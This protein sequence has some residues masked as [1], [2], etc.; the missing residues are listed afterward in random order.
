MTSTTAAIW[1]CSLNFSQTIHRSNYNLHYRLHQWWIKRFRMPVFI[2]VF[3]RVKSGMHT[4]ISNPYM[5]LFDLRHCEVGNSRAHSRFHS[6]DVGWNLEWTRKFP[7]M[8]LF[9]CS[10]DLS[11]SGLVDADLDVA[12]ATAEDTDVESDPHI[13]IDASIVPIY[14]VNY[15]PAA[16]MSVRNRTYP[17]S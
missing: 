11:R 6:S 8:I 4:A 9:C 2:S 14:G 12:Y 1:S 13:Q 16:N 15:T 7:T 10:L 5:I 17:A 3:I